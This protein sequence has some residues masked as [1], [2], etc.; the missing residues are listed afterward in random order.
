MTPATANLINTEFTD[1]TQK[2]AFD[3]RQISQPTAESAIM[4]SNCQVGS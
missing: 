3:N 1:A 2:F 4:Y